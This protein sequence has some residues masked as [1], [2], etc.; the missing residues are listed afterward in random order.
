ML[1]A[2]R[3]VVVLSWIAVFSGWVLQWLRARSR[4]SER[5]RRV[6]RASLI[7]MVLEF[8]AF[9]VLFL[10][11]RPDPSIP[12]SVC[13]LA[14]LLA[15]SSAVLGWAAGAYLGAQLR[16]QA[17]VT[18]THQLITSGPYSVIRHPIYACLL[19]FLISTGLV[20]SRPVA[21]LIAIPVMV[22][23]TEIRVRLEDKLLQA[24]FGEEF[25]A[26]RRR[27]SAWLPGIR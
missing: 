7:G 16:I 9:V 23:G 3:A 27:V 20:F 14:A 10:F 22:I 4:R 26:Y 15:V 12:G 24:H 25:E 1:T 21:L 11:P 2:A 19:G 17:V 13:V 5:G 18:D 8:S 6:S